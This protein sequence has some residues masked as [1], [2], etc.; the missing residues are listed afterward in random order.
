MSVLY[1]NKDNVNTCAVKCIDHLHKA[2]DLEHSDAGLILGDLY[3]NGIG[4]AKNTSKGLNIYLALALKKNDTLAM[5]KLANYYVKTDDEISAFNWFCQAA[6]AGYHRAFIKLAKCYKYGIGTTSN[7][8]NAEY[9]FRQ[10][11]PDLVAVLELG[12]MYEHLGFVY[13]AYLV[14]AT[15]GKMDVNILQKAIDLVVYGDVIINQDELKQLERNYKNLYYNKNYRDLLIIE[16]NEP[17]CAFMMYEAL[18]KENISIGMMSLGACYR[19]GIGCQQNYFLA[20]KWYLK[21]KNYQDVRLLIA[22]KKIDICDKYTAL[23]FENY[24]DEIEKYGEIPH[25]TIDLIKEKI[26]EA[27]ADNLKLENDDSNTKIFIPEKIAVLEEIKNVKGL[28][29]AMTQEE[30]IEFYLG[31]DYY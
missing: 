15:Y 24:I 8:R 16:M 27:H 12:E 1:H 19:D 11:L 7:F 21:C 22:D 4:V 14:Y 31:Y 18:A 20:I 30:F 9:W 10:V 25:K 23:L 17:R 3:M 2:Y 13:K 26:G 5:Y 28:L 29:P 6:E